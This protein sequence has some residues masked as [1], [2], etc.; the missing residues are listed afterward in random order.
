[1]FVGSSAFIVGI[2]IIY[3]F[4]SYEPSGTVLLLTGA[5]LAF[6]PGLFL[7][8]RGPREPADPLPGE[9]AGVVGAFPGTSVWPFVLAAGA[10]LAGIGLVFGPWTALPGVLLVLAAFVGGTL[11]SRGPH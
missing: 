6:I 7:L 3:W 1:V 11:E 8:R 5:G 10:A 9:G 2:G 4:T